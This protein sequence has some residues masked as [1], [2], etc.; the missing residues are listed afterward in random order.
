MKKWCPV[1]FCDQIII[2]IRRHLSNPNTHGIKKGSRE[3]QHL[4]ILVKNYTGVGEMQVD[5][6][7]PPPAII[8]V[9]QDP[10]SEGETGP[11]AS[12][13]ASTDAAS[14]TASGASAACKIP[15]TGTAS[16]ATPA[17]RTPSDPRR[18]SSAPG[19]EDG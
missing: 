13:S 17:P 9:V 3:F 14:A 15:G 2:D 7:P 12:G 4:M 16:G 1:P 18:T 8:E 5:L 19:D 6:Q 11:I 10:W